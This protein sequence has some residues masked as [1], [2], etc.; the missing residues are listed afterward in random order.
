MP[1]NLIASCARALQERG[2]TIAFAESVT[3]GRL[4]AEFSMTE[5]S[6]AILKGGLVC[7]DA[8][9]KKQLLGIDRTVIKRFTP[10]SEEVTRE[11]T[12]R[13][14]GLINS[15][16]QVG[17][18]GLAT[19]GGSET[20]QKPVGT[21]FLHLLIMGK[22]IAVSEVFEGTPEQIVLL[23]ADLAAKPLPTN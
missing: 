22:S 17:I 8:E 13:L 15:D 1:S 3:A 5:F 10:E 23:A 19:P 6:G 20:A 16:I 12:S 18:T 14:K 2:L 4:A 11:L 7:Y 9:V 21:I